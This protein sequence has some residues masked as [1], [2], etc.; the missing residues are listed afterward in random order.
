MATDDNLD[1]DGQMSIDDL[2]TAVDEKLLMGDDAN[3]VDDDAGDGSG[4]EDGQ[5]ED[6]ADIDELKKIAEDDGEGDG[7]ATN[8][9]EDKDD[10]DEESIP[11]ERFNQVYREMK[12]LK[13]ELK[14]LKDG[15][16]QDDGQPGETAKEIDI[17]ALR[18]EA[19]QALLDGKTDEYEDLQGQIDEEI[20]RRAEIR[21]EQRIETKREMQDFK[22]T[23]ARLTEEN[24]ILNPET[25][26]PKAIAAVVRARDE[27]AAQGMGMTEALKQAVADIVELVGSGKPNTTK[28]TDPTDNAGEKKPDARNVTAINRGAKDSNRVPPAGGGVGNRAMD[29]P[30]GGEIPQDKWDNLPQ[31]ERDKILAGG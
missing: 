16:T 31:V 24:P 22:A 29:M 3:P 20:Q 8:D 21:A 5:A 19:T 15:G 10:K 30:N 13:E 9:G 17:K 12:A 23:A 27:Y 25:G 11:K 7:R 4:G 1:Q 26:N 18:K 6:D 14:A 2:D 28:P